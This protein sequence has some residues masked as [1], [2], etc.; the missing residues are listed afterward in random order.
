[1]GVARWPFD[2]K[3]SMYQPSQQ[4]LGAILQDNE[5]MP[6]KVIWRSSELPLMSQ[7]QSARAQRAEQF[8]KRA[9]GYLWDLGLHCLILCNSPVPLPTP[10]CCTPHLPQVWFWWAL[11]IAHSPSPGCRQLTLS[12][13]VWSNLCQWQSTQAHGAWLPLPRFQRIE[14]P[15]TKVGTGP[16]PWRATGTAPIGSH[17]RVG[18]KQIWHEAVLLSLGDDV[19]TPLGLV[20]LMEFA[21]LS[22]GLTWDLSFIK[23]TPDPYPSHHVRTQGEDSNL[24]SEL[25]QLALNLQMPWSWTS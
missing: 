17:P 24:W 10:Q 15:G 18:P 22:F 13:S 25:S 14:L 5:R 9:C 19:A 20:G 1:M 3:I 6:P 16:L 7:A 11:G 8:Q 21:L 4:K 2:K 12:A 23:E